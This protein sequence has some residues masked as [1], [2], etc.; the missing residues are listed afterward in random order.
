MRCPGHTARYR[1][2][3]NGR[4]DGDGKARF[5]FKLLKVAQFLEWEV[6]HLAASVTRENVRDAAVMAKQS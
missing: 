1:R 5:H 3:D 4:A 2:D 6:G